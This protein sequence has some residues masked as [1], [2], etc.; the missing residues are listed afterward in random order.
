MGRKIT[1][2]A[3]DFDLPIDLQATQV[4]D[5]HWNGQT[6]DLSLNLVFG[7]Q[8][9]F[10]RTPISLAQAGLLVERLQSTLNKAT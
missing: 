6:I 4:V 5:A 8:S 7:G 10:L 3:G 1:I 2:E 9:E